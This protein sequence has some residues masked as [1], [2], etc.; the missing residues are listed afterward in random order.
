MLKKYKFIL[1]FLLFILFLFINNNVNASSDVENVR[2]SI[3]KTLTENLSYQDESGI[4]YKSNP[5]KYGQGNVNLDK[6]ITIYFIYDNPSLKCYDVISISTGYPEIKRF[7]NWAW[8]STQSTTE[9]YIRTTAGGDW[10]NTIIFEHYS[11]SYN[12][13][14]ISRV[15]KTKQA[16][17]NLGILSINSH[18]GLTNCTYDNLLMVSPNYI[19]VFK[20]IFPDFEE[21]I[22]NSSSLPNATIQYNEKTSSYWVYTDWYDVRE[23]AISTYYCY[24]KYEDFN[25]DDESQPWEFDNIVTEMQYDELGNYTYMQREGFELWAYAYYSYC[26]YDSL[27]NEYVIYGLDFTEEGLKGTEYEDCLNPLTNMNL[28]LDNR[29]EPPTVYSN[30]FDQELLDKYNF[31]DFSV[32]FDNGVTFSTVHIDCQEERILENKTYIRFYYKLFTNDTYVFKLTIYDE[33]Y[34]DYEVVKTFTID[35]H[36]EIIDSAGSDIVPASPF[37]TAYADSNIIRFSTQTFKE[38]VTLDIMGEV[39][40]LRYTAYYIDEEAY[41]LFGDNY[42][43]WI[44]LDVGYGEY[45]KVIEGYP[46]YFK[47][48]FPYDSLEDGDKFYFV[49]YDNKLGCFSPVTT[50]VLES[51]ADLLTLSQ[52]I[53]FNNDK[54]QRLFDFFTDHFGFLTYPFEFIINLLTRVLNINFEEPILRFPQIVNPLNDEVIFNGFDYNFNS[55][56]Q[57]E[58]IKY[59]YNIYLIA[60]DFILATAFVIGCKN[61]LEGV[62]G[63]G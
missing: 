16:A 23:Y 54:F 2:S 41:Q 27:L 6:P 26:V 12:Y 29:S 42:E 10:R 59:F 24:G 21:R 18:F 1:I 28:Y 38:R 53:T 17:T 47:T 63:N 51:K 33:N 34:N 8:Y 7:P 36:K 19:N 39:D 4:D 35:S 5:N 25:L 11:I 46:Y 30:F 37:I 62:L 32:S 31:V 40:T 9:H 60:V 55:I 13:E 56:L 20:S 52:N 22:S 49:F 3:L 15:R 43:D 57:Y 61:T 44:L 48:E 58:G 50:Y 45:D 14:F